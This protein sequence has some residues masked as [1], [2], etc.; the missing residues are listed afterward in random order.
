MS[1]QPIPTPFGEALY[2]HLNRPDTRYGEKYSVCLAMDPGNNP[3]HA[4]YLDQLKSIALKEVGEGAHLPI[5]DHV[6]G[7]VKVKFSSKF[8]PKLF[9]RD[10][11]PT[12]GVIGMGSIIQ[13]SA[14]PKAYK[15][16]G[17]KS[18]LTL[19]PVGVKVRELVEPWGTAEAFGF[20]PVESDELEARPQSVEDIPVEET[21]PFEE[22]LPVF[23]EAE[24][25]IPF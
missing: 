10:N 16:V 11:K 3:D 17:G 24:E 8:P 7:K 15:D 4:R 25:K 14:I 22:E 5:S 23:E 21:S 9:G 19:Y 2:P 1:R 20:G 12:T 18:G 6:D 13:V